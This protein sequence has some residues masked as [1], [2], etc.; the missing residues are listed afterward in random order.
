MTPYIAQTYFDMA[1]S[2]LLN[3][4]GEDRVAT[5]LHNAITGGMTNGNFK[6]KINRV[7]TLTP[8]ESKFFFEA[9]PFRVRNPRKHIM[10]GAT[11]ISYIKEYKQP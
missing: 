6:K 11:L 1:S 3:A 9:N 4:R 2:M 7:F 5:I 8:K 10:H